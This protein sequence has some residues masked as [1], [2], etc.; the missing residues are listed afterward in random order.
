MGIAQDP[1]LVWTAVEG[2]SRVRS[3]PQ[4]SADENKRKGKETANERESKS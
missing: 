2:P 4:S 1:A 3:N